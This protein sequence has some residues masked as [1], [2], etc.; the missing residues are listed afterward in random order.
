MS[1]TRRNAVE[2][3]LVMLTMVLAGC[4]PKVSID[5]TKAGNSGRNTTV[6][7]FGA[8]QKDNNKLSTYEKTYWA[9]QYWQERAN[10]TFSINDRPVIKRIKA[11]Q[12]LITIGAKDL[13]EQKQGTDYV[14]VVVDYSSAN[15]PWC[16]NAKWD[17]IKPLELTAEDG[18]VEKE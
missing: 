6:H 17:A 7:I 16:Y 4:G 9:W 10:G 15:G 8:T 18:L 5:A 14:Y 11:S 12:P 1:T 13:K 3:G 2:L